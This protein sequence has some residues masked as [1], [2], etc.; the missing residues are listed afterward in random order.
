MAVI[1]ALIDEAGIKVG[2][3]EPISAELFQLCQRVPWVAL[4]RSSLVI[5]P[6]AAQIRVVPDPQQ[7]LNG[8]SA[9]TIH[10]PCGPIVGRLRTRLLADHDLDNQ[11]PLRFPPAAVGGDRRNVGDNS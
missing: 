2:L 3:L 1:K 10:V 9:I 5:V 11:Q 6:S 4:E 8:E 7:S